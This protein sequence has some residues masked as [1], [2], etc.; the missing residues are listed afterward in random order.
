VLEVGAITVAPKGVDAIERAGAC[1][2]G[3]REVEF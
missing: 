2:Q 1:S 3:G